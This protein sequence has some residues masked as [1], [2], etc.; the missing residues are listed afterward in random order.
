MK[1]RLAKLGNHVLLILVLLSSMFP[2]FN[3]AVQA[4]PSPGL[5]NP[6]FE[7][8]ILDGAPKSWT[9]VAAPDV[10]K[11]VDSEGPGEF[12]TYVSGNITVSPYRGE[13][14]LR[15]G[16]PKEKAESQALFLRTRGSLSPLAFLLSERASM[17]NYILEKAG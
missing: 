2:L 8:G 15:L 5:Q 16:T 7:E 6:G 9:V 3:G 14:M 12:P 11:V 4:A 17:G 1:T 10:V 13:Y